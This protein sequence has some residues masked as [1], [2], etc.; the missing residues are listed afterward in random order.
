MIRQFPDMRGTLTD[1]LIGDLFHDRVDRVWAPLES[2]Y[3]KDKAP[4]PMWD[5]G[6]P[7]E[8]VPDKANDLMLPAGRRP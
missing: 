8:K 3:P 2:L 7:A 6:V 5:A 1:L 4:I